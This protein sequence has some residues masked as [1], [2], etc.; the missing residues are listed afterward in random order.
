MAR[1]VR[2]RGDTGPRCATE[3]LFDRMKIV[4]EERGNL[5]QSAGG[6]R[7][8][9]IDARLGEHVDRRRGAEEAVRSVVGVNLHDA[10]KLQNDLNYV[11]A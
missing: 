3:L 10:R 2:G 4:A 7:P 11:G 6:P 5:R 8:D 1:R 9:A